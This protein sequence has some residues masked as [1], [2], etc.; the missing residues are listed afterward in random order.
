M[1][2]LFIV[3][4]GLLIAAPSFAQTD[5]ALDPQN[6]IYLDL[7]YGR[8]VIK[9]HPELAPNTVARF[10]E[11]ARQGFYDGLKWHRVI[12]G[13]MAQTGDPRGDG[14]G[15]SGVLQKAE[16]NRAHHGRGAVSMARAQSP[17]SADSQ[18]FIVLADSGFLDGQYTIFGEVV[19]GMEFVDQIKK[20][21][22]GQN[23]TVAN[24]D[25]IKR[26]K[27]AADPDNMPK[28][29]PTAVPTMTGVTP[30]AVPT[31][32][33]AADFDGSKFTCK[34]YVDGLN[35]TASKGMQA[36]L[37]HLWI[38]GF[39]AGYYKAN[40]ALSFDGNPAVAAGLD[41][42]LAQS[43]KSFPDAS[44]RGVT[45]QVIAK[46]SRPLPAAIDAGFAPST[47]TCAKYADTKASDPA[48]A[49]FVSLW[50]YAFI[51][52]YKNATQAEM[53]ITPDNRGALIGVMTR[54]CGANRDMTFAD[55][56]AQIADKVKLK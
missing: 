54:Q 26:L 51:Q 53:V 30:T 31:A 52:G 27:V 34:K 49:E 8:V 16:F 29:K 50:G 15:G 47:Y 35:D 20:G 37:G 55:V 22:P 2:R 3:L 18:F 4:I 5:T 1:V 42:A 9:L 23:G 11:L 36:S 39:L 40:G 25:I 12:A 10:K 48:A 44:L 32:K 7:S 14:T 19:S 33:M 24:P 45:L 6:T 43:C 41:T 28:V 21:D 56:I 46:E 17:D 13:F 38:E